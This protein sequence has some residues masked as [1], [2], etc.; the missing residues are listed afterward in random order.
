[1]PTIDTTQAGLPGVP[2]CVLQSA[3]VRGIRAAE[4]AGAHTQ[5][6][7]T[8]PLVCGLNSTLQSL[9]FSSWFVFL[10]VPDHAFWC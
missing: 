3:G 7:V 8:E 10:Y 2:G 6:P 4:A 1:M 5:D 9:M